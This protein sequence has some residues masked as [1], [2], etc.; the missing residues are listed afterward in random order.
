V[1]EDAAI[2]TIVLA[3]SAN[4]L[5][6]DLNAKVTYLLEMTSSDV[7]HFLIDKDTGVIT[8]ARYVVYTTRQL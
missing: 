4:D 3:V 5:D 6:L 2:G 1:S 7:G 8:V